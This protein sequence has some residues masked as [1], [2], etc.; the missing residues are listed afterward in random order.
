MSG[1][2]PTTAKT[3]AKKD[4]PKETKGDEK[5]TEVD[6]DSEDEFKVIVK[7]LEPVS[8]LKSPGK[9]IKRANL[10]VT[11]KKPENKFDYIPSNY[12][13]SKTKN[14][15]ES[16]HMR[17]KHAEAKNPGKSPEWKERPKKER[18]TLYPDDF[19]LW[20]AC[21]PLC[22]RFYA[23]EVNMNEDNDRLDSIRFEVNFD[24]TLS[25]IFK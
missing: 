4:L 11:T 8:P 24:M 21:N 6:D 19:Y 20:Q 2:K 25:I 12:F 18:D 23:F 10:T 7:K 22:Y 1:K 13:C 17:R 15:N 9:R 14:M 3:G 5:I 16:P